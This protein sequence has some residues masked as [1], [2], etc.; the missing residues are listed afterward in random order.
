M[1]TFTTAPSPDQPLGQSAQARVAQYISVLHG[2]E[3][4]LVTTSKVT[5]A[6][7][8]AM[9]S[10]V[11]GIQS[12]V[13]YGFVETSTPASTPGGWILLTTRSGEPIYIRAASIGQVQ[14]VSDAAGMT[15]IHRSDL[16]VMTVREPIAEVLRMIGEVQP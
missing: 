14:S 9:R 16:G 10:A 11:N 15:T 1:S 7:V 2:L 6:Q 3:F 13:L 4:D 8:A 12:V 5:P